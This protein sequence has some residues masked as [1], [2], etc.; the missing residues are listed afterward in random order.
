[1]ERGWEA[2]GA[3][4]LDR[5]V[6]LPPSRLRRHLYVL[7]KTG[8]GK[9]VAL[10]HLIAQD[11]RLGHSF[12]VFDLRGGLARAALEICARAGVDPA[13]V[14]L[15]DLR[16]RL[17]PS[18]FDPLRGSGEAYFRALAVLA[19]IEAESASWGVT[20]EESLRNALLLL[21][22]AG[23]PLP[24]VEALFRDRAFLLA[25][26]ARCG[27][28][29]VLGFWNRYLGLSADRQ[30]ALAAPAL[31]KVSVFATEALRRVLGHPAPID[32]TAHLNRRGGVLLV[33][34]AADE[35]HAAGRVFGRVLLKSVVREVFARVDVPERLRTPV[36]MYVDEFQ[37]F[38]TEDFESILAESRAYGLSLVLAHQTLAQISARTRSLL[39]GNVGSK[40]IFACGREDEATLSRDLT[41]DPRALPLSGQR[42]GEAVLWTDAGGC[43]EVEV[44]QPIV[45]DA[46][47]LSG[48]GRRFV[49]AVQD[50]RA[51]ASPPEGRAPSGSSADEAP[52]HGPAQE[53]TVRRARVR[54]PQEDPAPRP[55]PGGATGTGN[56]LEDWLS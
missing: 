7:G 24:R 18:G 51:S 16:E 4:P 35:T 2:K 27:S 44:N 52:S 50:R 11:A 40:L 31:N 12:V 33:S 39:L 6:S 26:L 38:G 21:A 41:G 17:R 54:P 55:R 36:R 15:L 43:V 23:E 32:L 20:I 37:N 14:A 5:L 9:T 8:K 25:C 48:R 1:M 45:Q 47:A 10:H 49:R 22:E 13:R 30:E 56:D 19:A 29:S 34:L 46:G 3:G 28:E 53:P 42:V